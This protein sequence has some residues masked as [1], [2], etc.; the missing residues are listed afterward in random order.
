MRRLT[1]KQAEVWK[2][3]LTS[4]FKLLILTGAVRSGKSVINDKI[5]LKEL[6]EVRRR[7]DLLGV[8]TP[9]YILAGV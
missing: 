7:A 1:I 8:Q 3:Y 2:D 5:F 4:D 9:L 6:T